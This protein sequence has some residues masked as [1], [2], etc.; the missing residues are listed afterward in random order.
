MKRIVICCDGTWQRLYNDSLTNVALTARATAPRDAKGRSQIVYYSA[1]V[2]AHLGGV[3]IWQGMTGADLDDNLLDAYLFLNLNY[4]PGDEIYLFGFSRGAYTVRSLAGLL[5]RCGILRRAHVDKARDALDIYRQRKLAADSVTATRFRG[6]HAIAWPRLTR[7]GA[8]IDTPPVDLRIRYLGLWDTV[9]ALGIP[10]V[11][12]ISIGLND[13]YRFHDTALSR[14]VEAARHAVA[15]DEKRSAFA[16]T[17]WTNVDAFNKPGAPARVAQAWFPGD[18]GGV[19]GGDRVRG[20]SNCAL[21]WVLE[22]AEQMGLALVR[23]P[24]SVLS[25]AMAEIDPIGARLSGK[26]RASVLD[27]MGSRWRGG[28]M[29]YEDLHETARLRWVADRSYRP[30]PLQRFAGDIAASLQ[31]DARAA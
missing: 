13:I 23:E 16:P 15:I 24:G 7:D 10:R 3:S 29:R 30:K 21:L 12:P 8:T 11:L 14:A 18:H 20:L 17:L 1:G 5:R 31:A 28:L 6:A 22:G 2:G 9:G 27:L 26:T 19:G 25:G 4:E